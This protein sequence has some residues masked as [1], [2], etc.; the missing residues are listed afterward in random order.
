MFGTWSVRV[1]VRVLL[2]LVVLG[3]V[4]AALLLI[5][6]GDTT[7]VELEVRAVADLEVP[8]P[9]AEAGTTRPT[10]R[11]LG[12]AVREREPTVPALAPGLLVVVRATADQ[13][14]VAGAVVSLVLIEAPRGGEVRHQRLAAAH[15]GRDG[16]AALP[17]P[18]TRLPR[19][20]LAVVTA[21][22]GFARSIHYLSRPCPDRLVVELRPGASIHGRVLLAD[23]S[24]PDP[25]L[26]VR[27]YAWKQSWGLLPRGPGLSLLPSAKVAANGDFRI[28]GLEPGGR[29]AVGGGA[30][31]WRTSK[32]ARN[33][34]PGQELRLTLWR[35]F[36]GV[37]EIHGLPKVSAGSRLA[38]WKLLAG[39]PEPVSS[40]R[41]LVDRGLFGAMP[42]YGELGIRKPWACVFAYQVADPQAHLGRVRILF[43][44]PGFPICTAG[45]RVA[46][47]RR[48]IVRQVVELTPAAMGFGSLRIRL[49]SQRRRETTRAV[50]LS[51]ASFAAKVLLSGGGLRRP[52]AIPIASLE[53][54]EMRIDGIPAGTYQ[55]SFRPVALRPSNPANGRLQ[56]LPGGVAWLEFDVSRLRDLVVE[57]VGAGCQKLDG[58]VQVTARS[59]RGVIVGN[60]Y[61]LWP[62]Y[63]CPGLLP[64]RYRITVR[65][66]V[67]GGKERRVQRTVDV[68]ESPLVS[69]AQIAVPG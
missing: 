69:I 48:R 20:R 39:N 43:D 52:L 42:T 10:R 56:I 62:P 32:I 9:S 11:R 54:R 41:L 35:V 36:A 30:Y 5:F 23:G 45:V 13:R 65:F 57:L 6:A 51:S 64:G 68:F 53:K 15:T 27:V 26:G 40:S 59:Q 21:A 4:A 44:F 25:A 47:L 33:V 49:F 67:A 37:V 1:Q 31:G 17:R 28:G 55:V 66:R 24:P 8:N 61:F 3:L 60:W 38:G 14:A 12:E 63:R 7:P 34:T 50:G 2:G 58:G 29:Y 19:G 22:E 16:S 18:E 46:P